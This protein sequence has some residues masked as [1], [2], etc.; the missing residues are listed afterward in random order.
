MFIRTALAGSAVA[1]LV[2]VGTLSHAATQQPVPLQTDFL[3]APF[4][5]TAPFA[6]I[7]NFA[8]PA[9][10]ALSGEIQALNR[11]RLSD[12]EFTAPVAPGIDL[13]AGSNLD[14]VSRFSGAQSSG[15]GLFLTGGTTPYSALTGGG[16]FVGATVALAG[17]LHVSAAHSMLSPVQSSSDVP[18]FSILTQSNALQRSLYARSGQSTMAALDWDFASWGGLGVSASTTTEEDGLLGRANATA[19]LSMAKATSNAVG[20][21][22]HADFGGGWVTTVSYSQGITQLDLKAASLLGTTDT[23][24]YSVTV[25]KHGLFA[26][27]DSLGLAVSRP[28]QMFAGRLGVAS[29]DG[30]DANSNLDGENVS[31]LGRAPETDLELGYV[32][33]FFNGALALQA[34]AAW[35][36]NVSG[37]NGS[38]S[39]AVLSRAKIN[40]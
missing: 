7:G 29:A 20:A 35:Q 39:L 1:A 36:M 15:G 13:S 17:D 30:F 37:Q 27:N 3:S 22:A 8:N 12:F 25:A 28:I 34:N 24:A 23:R 21:S 9:P 38:N 2:V 6:V 14:L 40:F 11:A 5:S 19:A 18:L 10:V 33:S 26:D 4:S 31:L 32:T 16:N